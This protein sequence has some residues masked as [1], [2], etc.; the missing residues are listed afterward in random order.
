MRCQNIFPQSIAVVGPGIARHAVP[1]A[2][3]TGQDL[4]PHVEGGQDQVDAHLLQGEIEIDVP[5]P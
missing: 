5:N 4:L 1:P 2:Q 3:D